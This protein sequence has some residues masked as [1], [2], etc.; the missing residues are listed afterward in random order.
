MVLTK[1]PINKYWISWTELT[2][3]SRG[4]MIKFEYWEVNYLYTK[5]RTNRVRKLN[6]VREANI[7]NLL[8]IAYRSH[9]LKYSLDC[10]VQISI[11]FSQNKVLN[12]LHY[13]GLRHN[14]NIFI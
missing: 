12:V 9:P 6:E 1:Q 3:Y 2:Q 10:C 5:F 4:K 7:L 14:K 11:N 13:C 8:S